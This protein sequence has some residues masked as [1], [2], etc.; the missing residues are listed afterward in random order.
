VRP[1]ADRI[2]REQAAM[3]E[4]DSNYIQE[5]SG[6]VIIRDYEQEACIVLMFWPFAII[7]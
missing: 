7:A 5:R 2:L 6:W 1:R 3:M 4:V